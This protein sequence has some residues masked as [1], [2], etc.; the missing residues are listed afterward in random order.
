MFYKALFSC[1]LLTINMIFITC[2]DLQC[3]IVNYCTLIRRFHG[4]IISS[5]IEALEIILCPSKHSKHFR[6]VQ[7][8]LEP[9]TH[10]PFVGTLHAFR[11][12]TFLQG[13]LLLQ[14]M[15]LLKNRQGDNSNK[16]NC[17]LDA[18]VTALLKLF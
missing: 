17:R 16:N 12:R 13:L 7:V 8:H 6:I 10:I 3:I 18:I 4:K 2:T 14:M 15:L 11:S 9:L 5:S 1:L